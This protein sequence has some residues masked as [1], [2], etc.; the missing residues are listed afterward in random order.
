[1]ALTVRSQ[2]NYA[3]ALAWFEG[4]LQTVAELGHAADEDVMMLANIGITYFDMGDM[5]QPRPWLEQALAAARQND[6]WR[7]AYIGANLANL[8]GTE[9]DLD[10]AETLAQESDDLYQRQGD[11]LFQLEVLLVRADIALRRGD[12]ERADEL[13]RR[14]LEGYR[15]IGDPSGIANAQRIQA[16]LASVDRVGHRSFLG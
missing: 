3:Q 4:S 12:R 9:G 5:A 15:A 6:H 11:H 14:A 1:M 10:A 2:G 8:L 13:S 16:Q 7:T